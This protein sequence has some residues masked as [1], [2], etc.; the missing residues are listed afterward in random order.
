MVVGDVDGGR[1][2]LA[3]DVADLVHEAIAQRSIQRPER[4]V[5]QQEIGLGRQRAGE[6]DALRLAARQRA[7]RALPQPGEAD[8]LEQL[9][10]PSAALGT[11]DARHA[12]AERDVV[13]HVPV[14]EQRVIL[15]HQAHAALVRRYVGDV[16]A[17]PSNAPRLRRV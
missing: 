16:V 10:H 4:L 15:E 2:E 7:D 5:E 6:G 13:V 14:W 9:V 17:P 8:Q 11:S 3:D 12:H 1:P